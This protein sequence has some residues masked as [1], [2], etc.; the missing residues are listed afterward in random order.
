M[1]TLAASEAP[2]SAG[3]FAGVRGRDGFFRAGRDA[4]GRWWLLDPESLPCLLRCVH[5]VRAAGGADDGALPRDPAARLRAWGF[6]AAGISPAAVQDDGLP[7]LATAELAEA[8][9]R[10]TGPGLSLPDVFD[11]DWPRRAE[12]RAREVCTPLSGDRALVGWV[13]DDGLA[14]AGHAAGGRPSLLQQCLSLEP[15][16]AA[17]HAAWEFTLAL[18][19]GGLEAVARA[20]GVPLP[21]KEVVRG[22]T[23]AEEGITTRGYLR[24][25]ARWT[26]E[27]ARRYFATASGALRGADGNH[28]VLGCRFRGPVGAE[29]L[30]KCVY[31]AVDVALPHWRDL[32]PAGAQGAAQPVLAGELS[33]VEPDFLKAPPAMWAARLTSVELMLRRGRAQLERLARHPAVVGYAWAAWADEPGE[34]PPFA[35]GLVHINGAEAREHTELLTAFNLRAESLR[36]I[37]SSSH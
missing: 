17:Y 15:S 29:V 16:H 6:N 22:M 8:G 24:D 9:V 26:A 5:G 28:L 34:Q 13:S 12:A 18:H 30:A 2:A 27:F 36:Q 10:L 35:R 33:W 23:R 31:P 14:W 4:A 19:G 11:P 1:V 7:F 3:T 21:N 20:W 37:S 32:P 25:Q